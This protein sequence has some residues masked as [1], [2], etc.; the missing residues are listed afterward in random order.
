MAPLWQLCERGDLE[1]VVEALAQV[2]EAVVEEAL[3]KLTNVVVDIVIEDVEESHLLIVLSPRGLVPTPG[4]WRAP[5]KG[6]S[7]K[8]AVTSSS[9][10][11]GRQLFLLPPERDTWR[12]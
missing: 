6:H 1:G 9:P 3:R 11:F 2:E 4:Y 10:I 5:L 7:F 8:Q 12:L